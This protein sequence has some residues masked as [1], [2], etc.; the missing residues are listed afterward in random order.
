MPESSNFSTNQRQDQIVIRGCDGMA[1]LQACTELEKEIWRF[2]DRDV[3]PVRLYVIAQQI[4]GHVI[5]AFHENKLVGFAMSLPGVRTGR[6]YLYSR[7]LAVREDYRNAGLGRRLKLFQREEALSRGFDLIE[8]T[9]DPLEIKNAYLNIERLGAIVRRYHVNQYGAFSSG[10][11]GGLPSDRL[12]A[13]WWLH[14]HRV[15]TL[16]RS[17]TR[18]ATITDGTI[19]VPAEIYKWKASP[20]NRARAMEVQAQNRQGFLEAFSR[21]L[22]VLGY[23][24]DSKGNGQYL[25]GRW[26]EFE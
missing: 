24:V 15:N 3:V 5:G 6:A 11:Q 7:V 17:G 2:E 21:G 1:E 12:V 25:L 22:V 20:V 4:G 10:L 23:E 18:P 19:T 16:I 14:S 26:D 9:F 8:W 13:E